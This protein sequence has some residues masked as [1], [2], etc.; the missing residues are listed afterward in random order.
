MED[1]KDAKEHTCM[2][3]KGAK[4]T[5]DGKECNLDDLKKGVNL[6]VTTTGDS[7]TAS[8]IEGSTK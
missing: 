3:A 1:A 7:M 4:I 5:C 8:K 2:V 6:T